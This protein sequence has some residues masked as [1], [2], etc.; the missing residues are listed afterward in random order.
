MVEM[1]TEQ[2]RDAGRAAG[3]PTLENL[4]GALPRS[5]CF[6]SPFLS[7]LLGGS[8]RIVADKHHTI[9]HTASRCIY[10]YRSPAARSR[11]STGKCCSPRRGDHHAVR[12]RISVGELGGAVAGAQRGGALQPRGT[13]PQSKRDSG[14]RLGTA[15]FTRR[16]KNRTGVEAASK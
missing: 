13:A 12:R 8:R 1:A 16:R 15:N 4:G 2:P 9:V 10:P 14:S 5:A 7:W 11:V 3:Q 6:P